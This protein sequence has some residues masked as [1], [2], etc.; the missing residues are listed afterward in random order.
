[1][2]KPIFVLNGP[3]LNMLGLREPQIYGTATL[4]DIQRMASARASARGLTLDFRQTNH[5]GVMIEAI[6]EARTGAQGLIVNGGAWTHTSIALMDALKAAALPVIEVHLSNPF[7][8]EAFRQH[9]YV[10]LVARGVICGF[11]PQSYV[12][13]VDAMAALLQPDAPAGPA[14]G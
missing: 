4:D 8:R 2:A 14:P 5:E 6:L 9:S 1:M 10:S 12:L 13:A 7:A 3:S 11:G